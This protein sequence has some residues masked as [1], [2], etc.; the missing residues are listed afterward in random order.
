[1]KGFVSFIVFVVLVIV[2]FF[3][4]WSKVPD[5]V[6]N[7]LSKKLHVQVSIGDMRLMPR[8]ITVDKF[9][10]GNPSD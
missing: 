6:A 10:M 9:Q 2:V 3:V 4:F 5:M 8:T 1:M 7:N